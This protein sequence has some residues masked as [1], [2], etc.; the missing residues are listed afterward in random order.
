M[1]AGKYNKRLTLSYPVKA[2]SG[3][4]D[5]VTSWSNLGTVW[6][7]IEPLKG[8][9]SMVAS[10]LQAPQD[11]R[12]CIR[13]HPALSS[14]DATWRAEYNG[15]VYNIVTPVNVNLANREIELMCSTG[16]NDG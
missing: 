1:S 4:G 12:I 9:E 10:Q 5:A 2:E 16:V 15:L 7:S 14:M 13:Y 6:A 8:R 3:F 11:H